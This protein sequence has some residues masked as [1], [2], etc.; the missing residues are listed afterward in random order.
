MTYL[1]VWDA[2]PQI[3]TWR[4][5][6][7]KSSAFFKVSPPLHLSMIRWNRLKLWLKTLLI[8]ILFLQ[9]PNLHCCWIILKSLSFC[10]L[11]SSQK[12]RFSSEPCE[13]TQKSLAGFCLPPLLKNF[14]PLYYHWSKYLLYLMM[15]KP[16][17]TSRSAVILGK[18]FGAQTNLYNINPLSDFWNKI[19]IKKFI[20]KLH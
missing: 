16:G 9:F 8:V 5:L 12:S 20:R 4:C 2:L 19:R 18:D 10:F 3:G 15:S 14:L 17:T 7:Q 6:P 1:R 13:I 11:L